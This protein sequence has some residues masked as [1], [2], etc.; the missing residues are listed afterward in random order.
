M[1]DPTEP[2]VCPLRQQTYGFLCGCPRCT[3]EAA[4]PEAV[5]SFVDVA[6]AASDTANQVGQRQRAWCL[7][8][9]NQVGQRASNCT[10]SRQGFGFRA[11][12]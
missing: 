2:P 12:A 7:S 3:F 1:D 10:L 5:T 9:A 8:T 6:Y 11:P 4:L